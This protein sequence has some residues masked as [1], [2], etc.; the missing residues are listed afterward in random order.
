MKDFLRADGTRGIP[1]ELFTGAKGEPGEKGK[2]S[3]IGGFKYAPEEEKP[4]YKPLRMLPENEALCIKLFR[5][6]FSTNKPANVKA[7]SYGTIIYIRGGFDDLAK[8]DS[9]CLSIT[10]TGCVKAEMNE[11]PV[12]INN[13]KL[14]DL[15]RA[16]GYSNVKWL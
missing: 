3:I 16:A 14:V 11:K 12:F 7:I 8:S 6:A 15:I 13:F 9:A 5:L 2:R 10:T 4:K 1:D